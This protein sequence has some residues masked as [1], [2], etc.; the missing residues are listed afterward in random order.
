MPWSNSNFITLPDL[1]VAYRKAKVDAFYERTQPSA[2]AFARYEADLPKRLERL[3]GLICDPAPSWFQNKNFLGRFRYVPKSVVAPTDLADNEVHFHTCDAIEDWRRAYEK[4]NKPFEASFRLVINPSID[5][6][7]ISALWILKVGHLFDARLDPEHSYGNR[8]RREKTSDE[9][10]PTPGRINREVHGLFAPY[11]SAYCQW[12]E[13]GLAAMREELQ[14]NRSILAL[15]MDLKRFYH[16]IDRRFLLLPEFLKVINVKLNPDERTFT[17]QL[18]QA[19]KTWAAKTPDHANAPDIGLPVGLS[20]S[21]IISNVLLFEFDTLIRD[22]LS[23]I[24]YGRYVD[25][26]FLVLRGRRSFKSGE[27]VLRWLAK[28]LEPHL[29]FEATDQ[30]SGPRLV[31]Q[32]PYAGESALVFVGDKLKIFPLHGREGLDLVEQLSGQITKQTSERRMLPDLPDDDAAIVNSA[33]LATPDESLD[34]DALR[35]ADA[36]SLR[37][38]GFSILLG[39]AEAH[40]RDLLPREWAELRHRFVGLVERHVV[41]PKGFFDYAAWLHRAF[42]L[43]ITCGD[44]PSALEFLDRFDK[45]VQCLRETTTA[46]VETSAEQCRS[47][48]ACYVDFFTEAALQAATLED[49]SWSADF[50]RI[51]D[52][53]RCMSSTACV[54][55]NSTEAEGLIEKLL[56]SD[57]GRRPYRQYWS[58][59]HGTLSKARIPR[60][61]K[62]VLEAIRYREVHQFQETAGLPT[63]HLCVHFPTRPF[64]L[65]EITEL[66]PVLLEDVKGQRIKDA[67]YGLRGVRL[68]NDRMPAF[69]N[70]KE[71]VVPTR[72]RERVRVAVTSWLTTD[73]D[74]EAAARCRPQLTLA[75]YRRLNRLVNQILEEPSRPDYI[76]LPELSLPRNW[77]RGISQ[78]LASR[79]ISLI[80]GLEYERR[81]AQAANEVLI[82]LVTNAPGYDT[83]VTL[84]QTKLAAAYDEA[85]M[86][87]QKVNASL[88]PPPSAPWDKPVYVHGG[89]CFG[90]LICSDLTS[91]QNRAHFQGFVDSLFV[92]EWNQDLPTF[93]FL[94][95]SA[96]H[97][98]HAF[99]V[100]ANNRKYG[101]SRIRGPFREEHRRDVVRVRGGVHDYFVVGELN[102]QALRRFQS[103]HEPSNVGEFKPFPIGFQISHRRHIAGNEG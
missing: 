18:L 14:N 28:R 72:E 5:F 25:D 15:T 4:G 63:P 71:L 59:H 20:A 50:G 19:M 75:R 58:S 21:K 38:L 49:F 41:T 84:K 88:T 79:G 24:Y 57:L 73:S 53:L 82:S 17:S 74:W 34:A 103:D 66:A 81:G 6:H 30:A 60:L 100:Q 65:P 62:T 32:L 95:D 45:V 70:S 99:I 61:P 9:E 35:K 90:V 11:F 67:L 56:V 64:A 43:M 87:R 68:R 1:Y 102:Y 7:I 48:V 2:I 83:F 33:L 23:T 46:G 47:A 54:P 36:I 89:F 92:V 29:R 8:L 77:A 44:F 94:V 51:V 91:I 37:R 13:R 22:E 40:A 3:L 80:A 78:K 76:V 12:R 96:A 31:L 97:D 10:A 39:N 16:Q 42:G 69:R 85:R 86:L 101:D 52:R 93:G 98:V 27:E 55:A 26:V